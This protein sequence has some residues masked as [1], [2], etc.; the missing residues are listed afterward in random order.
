MASA[1]KTF[2]NVGVLQTVWR[3]TISDNAIDYPQRSLSNDIEQRVRLSRR[4]RL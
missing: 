4:P 3:P 2:I 1:E